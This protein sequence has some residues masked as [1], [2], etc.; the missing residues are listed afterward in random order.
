MRA[1]GGDVRARRACVGRGSAGSGRQPTGGPGAHAAPLSGRGGV[2]VGG[3]RHARPSP[4]WFTSKEVGEG[5]GEGMKGAA[6]D[7]LG[8]A[9]SEP[10]L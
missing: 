3:G 2:T 8:L 10:W 9:G 5:A 4:W 7:R 6:R 1:R